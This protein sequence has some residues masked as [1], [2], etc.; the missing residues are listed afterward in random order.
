ME[1]KTVEEN[2]IH[3]CV[4][5]C[6]EHPVCGSENIIFGSAKGDDNVAACSIYEPVELR[7]PKH[8][9]AGQI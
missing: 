8:K 7:H 9:G 1:I 3:L 5:C 6:K 2:E 4:S